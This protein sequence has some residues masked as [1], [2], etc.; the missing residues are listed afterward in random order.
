MAVQCQDLGKQVIVAD[1]N[2]QLIWKIPQKDVKSLDGGERVFVRIDCCSRTLQ[3]VIS[4]K[5]SKGGQD[6]Q[7]MGRSI[8]NNEALLDMLKQRNALQDGEADSEK[9]QCSLFVE[10]DSQTPEAKKQ[11]TARTPRADMKFARLHPHM[12]SM[13]LKTP[14]GTT[15]VWVLKYVHPRDALFVEFEPDQIEAVLYQLWSSDWS[16]GV[17]RK[18][19]PTLPKGVWFHNKKYLVH[20][21]DNVFGKMVSRSF[22]TL[23]DATAAML[24]A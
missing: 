9:K 8:A 10:V 13:D 5:N 18:R 17:G 2:K 16:D 23:E 1:G 7:G 24:G 12:L 20:V 11:K 3:K 19:D 6:E 4:S 21:K 14:A 15:T 22:S